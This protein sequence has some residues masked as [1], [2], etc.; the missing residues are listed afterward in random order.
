MVYLPECSVGPMTGVA[1]MP[2]GHRMPP[3][4]PPVAGGVHV[5]AKC[6][7]QSDL[8]RSRRRCA[9]MLSETPVSMH[10]LFR[11]RRSVHASRDQRRK[12]RVH[13]PGFVV[14]LE[15]STAASCP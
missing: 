13:L 6:F 8:A 14:E 3:P 5:L 4:R 10:D 2:P 12:Q 9:K 7:F 1:V 11:A 15:S